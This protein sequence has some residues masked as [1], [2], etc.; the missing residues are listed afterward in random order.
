VTALGEVSLLR[1]YPVKSMLGEELTELAVDE[2]GVA[3]DRGLALLDVATGRVATAKQ[4]RLW[5][6][7]LQCAAR[8]HDDGDVV[9]TLP[10]GRDVLAEQAD[11]A[12]SE[13]LGRKVRLARE[14][15]DGAAVERPDPVDVLEHGLDADVGYELLEIA[16]ATPGASFVDHSPLHVITTATLDAIGVEALRY[17]PNVVVA[18]PPG[19][20]PYAEN[21]W[22][23]R[24]V[25]L[26]SIRARATLPTPRCSVPTL[27]HGPL[28]RAPRAL[29]VPAAENM[30]EV[31]G[32]GTLPC[33][34]VYLEVVEGG[35]LR[36]GDAVRFG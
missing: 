8:L 12:L 21:I 33:A 36:L 10:D 32:F 4:P 7:L 24:E 30:V 34:G 26:G 27:E 22:L 18:T 23:G 14:R 17:R 5:R 28:G 20:P 29:R 35:T 2:R 1:R 3:N 11:G 25:R 31:E 13:L 19:H 15:P 16:E 9:V 6:A